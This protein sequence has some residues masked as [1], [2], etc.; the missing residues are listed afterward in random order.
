MKIVYAPNY[1]FFTVSFSEE[2]QFLYRCVTLDI[3]VE[4]EINE[5]FKVPHV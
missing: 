4:S 3:G 1:V 2:V 5:K